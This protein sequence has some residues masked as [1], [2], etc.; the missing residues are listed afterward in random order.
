MLPV[1]GG[2]KK[3]AFLTVAL[4]AWTPVPAQ[5]DVV[6]RATCGDLKGPRVDMD[7]E[8]GSK[9]DKWKSEHYP[10]GP[11]P[12]GTGTLTFVSDD[13]DTGHVRMR[14]TANSETLLPVVFKSDTQIT[15]ADVD[16]YG[17]WLFS[18]YYRAGKVIVTRQTT[19]PGPGAIGTLLVGECEF[20][21]K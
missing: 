18:L 11:P 8:N 20:V 16:D 21:E 3:L 14:W 7:P 17:V 9:P 4:V 6:F 13:T 15:V 10:A 1:M 2:F 19:N 12:E 5:A